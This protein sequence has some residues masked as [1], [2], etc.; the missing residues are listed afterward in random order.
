[1]GIGST[2]FVHQV[3]ASLLES[4]CE[5]LYKNETRGVNGAAFR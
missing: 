2:D 1:M 4:V 5:Y 3:L